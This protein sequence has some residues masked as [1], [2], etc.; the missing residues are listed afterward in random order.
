[1]FSKLI[2]LALCALSFVQAFP[3]SYNQNAISCA[4]SVDYEVAPQ[5]DLS[6]QDLPGP[7]PL[8]LRNV[9]IKGTGA[10]VAAGSGEVL[11]DRSNDQHGNDGMWIAVQSGSTYK[12]G[13][14][15]RNM[16]VSV[17]E[18]NRLFVRQG[19]TPAAFSLLYN[20]ADTY[21]IQL[22]GQNLVWEGI[23]GS[24]GYGYVGLQ[25]RSTGNQDW[26]WTRS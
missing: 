9:G 6:V 2:P 4:V 23:Y 10:F 3:V 21:K 17:G 7:S 5:G 26:Q 18:G 8:R 1:M 14:V 13:N 24:T 15:G 25:P 22:A 20:G 11:I 12:I 16:F 19:A